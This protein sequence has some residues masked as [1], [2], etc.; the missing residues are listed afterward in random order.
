[1]ERILKFRDFLNEGIISDTRN[2]QSPA[3]SIHDKKPGDVIEINGDECEIVKFKSW[4][5]NGEAL[6]I[7]FIGKIDGRLVDVFYDEGVDGYVTRDI[8]KS[9]NESKIN[10]AEELDGEISE[11][12]KKLIKEE[13]CEQVDVAYI[14]IKTPFELN[15]DAPNKDWINK[16]GM[17]FYPE[18]ITYTENGKSMNTPWIACRIELENISDEKLIGD[19]LKWLV[20]LLKKSGYKP[21]MDEDA[22]WNHWKADNSHKDWKEYTCYINPS[23]PDG[24][25][26]NHAIE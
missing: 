4:I 13:C 10:I 19:L 6:C 9:L 15:P 12:V 11:V 23:Y 14:E 5:K 16:V 24:Y 20:D 17:V 3:F 26:E 7:S 1:M 21:F 2:I 25:W 22:K 18:L 8:K